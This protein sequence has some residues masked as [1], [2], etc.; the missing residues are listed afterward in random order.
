[1]CC[2]TQLPGKS[3]QLLG[4][5]STTK[6]SEFKFPSLYRSQC[7]SYLFKKSKGKKD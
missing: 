4:I 1:M 5:K 7:V 3:S 6:I 2:A